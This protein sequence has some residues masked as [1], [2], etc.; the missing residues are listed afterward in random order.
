MSTV[1]NLNILILKAKGNNLNNI[2]HHH[3]EGKFIRSHVC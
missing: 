2:K 3:N 1:Q